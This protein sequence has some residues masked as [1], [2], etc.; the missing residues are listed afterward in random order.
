MGQKK[1]CLEPF[2]RNNIVIHLFGH[3]VIGLSKE[4]S[5][6]KTNSCKL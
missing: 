6:T 5:L 4:S 2:Y 1:V 3:N